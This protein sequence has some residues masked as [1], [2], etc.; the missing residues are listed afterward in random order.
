MRSQNVRIH[1]IFFLV[2]LQLSQTENIFFCDI[3]PDFTPVETANNLYH[4]ELYKRDEKRY[5]QVG[6]NSRMSQ[7][8]VKFAHPVFFSTGEG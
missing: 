5:S 3:L 8:R 7:D 6:S 1:Q 2:Y 4:R